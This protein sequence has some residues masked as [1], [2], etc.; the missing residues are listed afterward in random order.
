MM[1]KHTS[2]ERREALAFGR[3]KRTVHSWPVA[4][5]IPIW[6]SVADNLIARVVGE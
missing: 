5:G 6:L 2:K 1:T 4:P 3:V